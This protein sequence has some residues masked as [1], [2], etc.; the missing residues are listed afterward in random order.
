M[1]TSTPTPATV[2]P[3]F[4]G[5]TLLAL[6]PKGRVA[7]PTK[8]REALF[9]AEGQLVVTAGQGEFLMIYPKAL[10]EPK[11]AELMSLPSFDKRVA[12]LQRR[13]V[14]YADDVAPDSAGRILIAP[15]LRELA[16]LDKQVALVGQGA[17]FELWDKALWDAQ[18]EE[19]ETLLTGDGALPAA[20]EGFAL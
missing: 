10:W 17:R 12:A 2:T 14:G 7:V 5:V 19:A 15:S 9:G 20:L 16:K 3:N 11:Q 18:M 4:R 8:Y 6:D 13:L 1:E